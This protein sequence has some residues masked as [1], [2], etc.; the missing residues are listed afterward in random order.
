MPGRLIFRKL[1]LE[2]LKGIWPIIAVLLN[3]KE[4]DGMA[5]KIMMALVMGM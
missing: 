4:L 3:D 2:M 1:L 5:R